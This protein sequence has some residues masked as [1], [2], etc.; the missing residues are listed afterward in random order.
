MRILGMNSTNGHGPCLTIIS[1]KISHSRN[2]GSIRCWV[3]KDESGQV[4]PWMVLLILMILGF[5]ALVVDI[6]HGIVV[7]R[8][9]QASTDAAALAAAHALQTSTYAAVAQS[10]SAA[11]GQKN[12]YAGISVGTPTVT[13]LCLATVTSWGNPCTDVATNPNAV[14]VSET[15]TIPT[16]FAGV[17][18]IKTMTV[19]ATSTAAKGAKPLPYNIAIVLDTTPSMDYDD[20][21]CGATQLQCAT[22]GVQQLLTGLAPSLDS[23]SL[24]TFPNITTDSVSDDYDCSSSSPTVGPYTFPSTTATSLSTM[25]YTTGTGKNASTAQMTYQVTDYLTDYRTSDS[26][27]SL[28]THSQLAN[29][30]GVGRGKG[31][32]S[33]CTGIQTSNENTYYAGA[34]YAAQSSL[35][36]AQTANKGTQNV[37]IFLSD[38][39]ATAKVTT[40]GGAFQ[41][42]VNDM[43]SSSSQSTVY[44]TNSGKYPSWVGECGQGVDA[45]QYAASQGTTVFT[46]AYGSPASSNSSNCASDRVGGAH[47]N[48]TPCQ[49]MQQMSSGWTAANPD[50]SHFYS[51]Y[52]MTGGD[53]GCQAAGPLYSVD[54]LNTIF[55]SILVNLTAARLIPNGTP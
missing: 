48:I 25:P 38:G 1:E 53:S 44:A 4:L 27:K 40:P 12:A 15:A 51:D 46:I 29:A 5:A 52:K 49:A 30:V 50:Y 37:I 26:S 6:G 47:Q 14:S 2:H 22:K 54:S 10:Y 42:G 39:N 32:H 33:G 19:S 13:P 45:A 21:S 3:F 8:Q 31:K 7:Q 23:V 55:Q 36:A 16:F 28:D 34:I 9:L 11:L 43:V 18:G 17:L 35:M 24:F 41:P 20:Y